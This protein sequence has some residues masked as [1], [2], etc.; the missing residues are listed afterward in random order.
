MIMGHAPIILP[1]VARVK[2]RF[3]LHFYVP[4]AA[5]HAS[6][7]VQTGWGLF[8]LPV[9]ATGA[10]LNA[11]AIGLFAATVAG[12]AFAGRSRPHDSG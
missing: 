2:L 5:L 11:V 1:A 3:G 6:L 12:S 10:T 8:D 4:L 9:R 7:I